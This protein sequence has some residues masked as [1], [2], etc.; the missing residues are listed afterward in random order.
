MYKNIP[1]ESE[2]DKAS[3]GKNSTVSKSSFKLHNGYEETMIATIETFQPGE[4]HPTKEKS[5]AL[6]TKEPARFGQD[7]DHCLC[8]VA[9]PVFKLCQLFGFLPI[10]VNRKEHKVYHSMKSFPTSLSVLSILFGAIGIFFWFPKFF[11]L[12][13]SYY[14][15]ADFYPNMISLTVE[16]LAANIL[17]FRSISAAK[18]FANGKP[19]VARLLSFIS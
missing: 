11:G 12:L 14:K 9:S 16:V 6:K 13:N 3:L 8:A 7:E 1:W 2:D 4:G 18:R 17:F 5:Y 10:S 19:F 15:G